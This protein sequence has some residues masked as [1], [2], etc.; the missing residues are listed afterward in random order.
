M[1]RRFNV[2]LTIWLF[3]FFFF[4]YIAPVCQGYSYDYTMILL[5]SGWSI[6]THTYSYML[7]LCS[8]W[9]S[10][11][12]Q[13]LSGCLIPE[14]GNPVGITE[15]L[16]SSNKSLTSSWVKQILL[17]K[18]GGSWPGS[19]CSAKYAEHT[20]PHGRSFFFLLL[21]GSDPFKRIGRKVNLCNIILSKRGPF[22]VHS[23]NCTI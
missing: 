8:H 22:C 9:D 7:G 3:F 18:A 5:H 11:A 2:S 12:Q 19:V 17:V 14:L 21:P 10:F 1:T 20:L 6:H 13:G 16:E 23:K 15:A 4:R